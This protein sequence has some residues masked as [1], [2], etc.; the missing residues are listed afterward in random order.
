MDDNKKTP[1]KGLLKNT[2]FRSA[3]SYLVFPLSLTAAA[4]AIAASQLLAP[5]TG[6]LFPTAEDYLKQ[7]GV[8]PEIV[9]E[10]SDREI[11]VRSRNFPGIAHAMFESPFTAFSLYAKWNTLATPYNAYATRGVQIGGLSLYDTFNQCQVMMP[12]EGISAKKFMSVT[13]G[14]PED[15]IENMPVTDE[16][17]FMTIGFHEF[18]H[19]H[20]DNANITPLTEGDADIGAIRA[21]LKTFNNPDIFPMWLHFRAM[22][23]DDE[24]DTSLLLDQ[25]RRNLDIP[26][27]ELVHHA[28]REAIILA[29]LYLDTDSAR[30][31]HIRYAEAF[32]KALEVNGHNMSTLAKR[33]AELYIQAAQ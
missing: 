29:R 16:E 13:T 23:L 15:M 26:S 4:G 6:L 19:C 27:M 33:R 21:S 10:L 5:M 14:I 32:R 3:F 17:M 31:H 1:K 28:N 2:F 12:G 9:S 18:R 8:D 24:H 20:S 30:P 7:R 22:A 11:R 25:L